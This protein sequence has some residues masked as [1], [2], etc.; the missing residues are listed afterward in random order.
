MIRL[1]IFFIFRHQNNIN[2]RSLLTTAEPIVQIPYLCKNGDF[3]ESFKVGDFI[4]SLI[5]L[6]LKQKSDIQPLVLS[7]KFHLF[8]LKARKLLNDISNN[9]LKIIFFKSGFNRCMP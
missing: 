2:L 8:T 9:Y 3:I 7:D 5:L 6:L 1:K 4:E